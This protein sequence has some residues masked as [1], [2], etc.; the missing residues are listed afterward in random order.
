M[1]RSEARVPTDRP[2]RYAKQLASHLGRRS[3]TSW[4]EETG[5]GGIVFQNGT[6]T[7]TATEGAL[8]LTV[9]TDPEH[10]GVLEGVVGRHLVRFGTRDELV[11][12]WRRD[13]GEPGTT[14]RNSEDQAAR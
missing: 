6:G 7:L 4:D 12:A 9:D 1:A 11:V 14:Q 5:T 3:Q 8:L 13:N 2:A 10:L